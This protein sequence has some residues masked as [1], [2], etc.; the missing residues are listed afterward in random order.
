MVFSE[1]LSET[2]PTTIP[3]AQAEI[4]EDP[5]RLVAGLTFSADTY[6]IV[7]NKPRSITVSYRG[8][9]VPHLEL[10][11]SEPE[12]VVTVPTEHSLNNGVYRWEC[13][14]SSS[15]LGATGTLTA[16]VEDQCSQAQVKVVQKEETVILK[17]PKI[18]DVDWGFVRVKW[19]TD[20]P[21]R[22]EIAA[23][24]PSFVPYLGSAEAGYPGRDS[25]GYRAVLAEAIAEA[26]AWRI[27]EKRYGHAGAAQDMMVM[28]Y[29]TEY[30]AQMR[31]FIAVM[32]E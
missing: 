10:Q 4:Q 25:E 32:N 11:C 1:R 12:I 19:S 27:L 29:Y 17:P 20:E 31:D 26:L 3:R 2:L 30:S 23:R 24:H 7:V 8:S 14:L 16:T 5:G 15:K 21:G 22:L 18:L 9:T 6:Q 28:D 13:T